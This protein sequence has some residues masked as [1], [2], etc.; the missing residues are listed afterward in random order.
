MIVRLL[1]MMLIQWRCCR[2]RGWRGREA[3]AAS[4][5]DDDTM[6]M[7]MKTTTRLAREG[8]L[9]PGRDS[10]ATHAESRAA[11]QVAHRLFR[12]H[13]GCTGCTLLGP[14]ECLLYEPGST[15]IYY[16]ALAG[17]NV[18]TMLC[19]SDCF[20]LSSNAEQFIAHVGVIEKNCKLARAFFFSKKDGSFC[21][22]WGKEGLRMGTEAHQVINPS[23]AA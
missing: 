2:W 20:N 19:Q 18:N 8:G 22:K 16:V 11:I 4:G 15:F 14:P 13:T 6:M 17:S 3:E 7:M 10:S 5:D 9:P 21:G 1:I 23:R 12:L